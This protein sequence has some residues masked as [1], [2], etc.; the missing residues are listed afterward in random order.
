MNATPQLDESDRARTG[1]A[2]LDEVLQGGLTRHQV[3]LIQGEPGAGK[4][5]LAMQFLLEGAKDRERGLYVS[6][7]ESEED[8]RANARSHGWSL[9]SIHVSEVRLANEHLVPDSRYTMFHPSDIELRETI[10]KVLEDVDRLQPARV[11]IDSLDE[12]RL[13]TPELLRHRRQ[14][15]ALKQFFAARRTTVLFLDESAKGPGEPQLQ[16]LVHGVI[17]LDVLPASPGSP[18]RRLRVVKMRGRSVQG[19][20]HDF[21]I[22]TGGLEVF[23]RLVSPVRR[24]SAD[25]GATLGGVQGLDQLLGGGLRRGGSTLLVGPA[26]T[27]KS[28]VAAQYA[29]AAARRGERA[30]LFCFDEAVDVLAARCRSLG[31][32]LEDLETQEKLAL[33]S[34]DP[35]GTSP[36]EFADAVRREVEGRG[37]SLVVIDTLEG[38]ASGLGESS[39][40]KVHLRELMGWLGGSGVTAVFVSAGDGPSID[41]GR[42]AEAVVSFGRFEG[43]GE[44]RLGAGVSKNRSGPHERRPREVRFDQGG[45]WVGEPLAGT[46]STAGGDH[47]R[48]DA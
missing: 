6:L 46:S 38:W 31:L 37:A 32:P 24:R 47:A 39:G 19:G 17:A 41:A 36:G 9:D 18:R 8:L 15:L 33:R 11:V 45:L 10:Q 7:S 28:T 26:G 4:T 29:V 40:A 21:R 5:T 12:L 14:V 23:P 42:L 2:G 1:I 25:S 48:G 20:D 22:V 13:L 30:V 43:G 3:H 44:V 34:I 35:A 27:G 16:S